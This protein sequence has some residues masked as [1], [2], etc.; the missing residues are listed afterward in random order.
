VEKLI[1]KRFV[2]VVVVVFAV[3]AVCCRCSS[4]VADNSLS[5]ELTA[6]YDPVA[7]YSTGFARISLSTSHELQ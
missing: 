2:V 4:A 3:A 5:A 6:R 1:S 7:A